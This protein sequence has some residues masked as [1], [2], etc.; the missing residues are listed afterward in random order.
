M[1]RATARARRGTIVALGG[2]IAIM[3]LLSDSRPLEAARA[4]EPCDGG[5]PLSVWSTQQPA[6]Q[7]RKR[8]RFEA[9]EDVSL[10]SKV[11]DKLNALAE[12]FRKKTGKTF[13]VTSGTRDP[14][15]QAQLIYVKL[16]GG[17]DLLKL[18][19]DRAAVL[20]LKRIY[21][22]GREE[23][24][25]RSSVVTQLA[26]TIRAQMKRGVFISAHLRSGAADVRSTN[27]SDLEKRAFSDIARD[28]GLSVMLEATPP[29]F[30]LQ[31]DL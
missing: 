26:S 16:Q 8:G 11:E 21:D 15:A 13:V 14:D 25:S 10:S 22:A 23:R 18:Y 29:H 24:L 12:R 7:A 17:E 27:M 5:E 30:H 19:K 1:I 20:E 9:L 6:P 4:F 28:H 3:A 2:A 31:L